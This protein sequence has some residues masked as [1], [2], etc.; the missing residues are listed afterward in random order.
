MGLP[1][2]S[3]E[4]KQLIVKVYPRLKYYVGQDGQL[5]CK[6][7]KVLYGY[8]QA[9]KLWYEKLCRFLE[10]EG[11]EHSEMDPCVLR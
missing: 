7:K 2:T 10:R 5:Y 6:L 4:L 1:Y 3:G 8:M 9:S 11:Y